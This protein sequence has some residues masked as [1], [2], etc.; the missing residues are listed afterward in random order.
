MS[1]YIYSDRLLWADFQETNDMIAWAK[2]Q[3]P[4]YITVDITVDIEAENRARHYNFYFSEEK[5]YVMFVLRWG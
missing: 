3:C 5:D 4:S 2:K 1:C